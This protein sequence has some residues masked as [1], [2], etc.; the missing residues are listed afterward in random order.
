MLINYYQA[1]LVLFFLDF[2]RVTTRERYCP[3]C[4]SSAVNRPI[5]DDDREKRKPHRAK[6]SGR[7]AEKK[8]KKN[9]GTKAVSQ[10]GMSAKQRNPK[11]FAVQNVTK[12]KKRVRR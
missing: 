9:E 5:M 4:N 8:A 7:K 3:C 1:D 12:L 2:I 10:A 11:A 6:T